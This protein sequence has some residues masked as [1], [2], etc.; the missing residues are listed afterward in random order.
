MRQNFKGDKR[1]KEEARKKKQED[2]RNR[3]LHKRDSTVTAD[4]GTPNELPEAIQQN[5]PF[6]V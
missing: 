4:A 3:R 1:R 6:N 2:K 5:T